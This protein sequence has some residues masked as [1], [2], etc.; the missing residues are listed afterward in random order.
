MERR[1]PGA[2]VGVRAD[3]EVRPPGTTVHSHGAW[4]RTL[5]REGGVPPPP[6]LA[7]ENPF[8]SVGFFDVGKPWPMNDSSLTRKLPVRVMADDREAQSGVVEVFR[9]LGDLQV[10]IRRFTVGDYE[11][12]GCCLFERKTVSDFAT[13]AGFFFKPKSWLRCHGRWR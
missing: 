3:V 11:V 10:T 6:K 2:S 7:G 8:A 12:D 1:P 13:W 5:S 4:I 9:R